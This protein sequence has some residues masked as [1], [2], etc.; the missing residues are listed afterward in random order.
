MDNLDDVIYRDIGLRIREIRVRKKLSQAEL[1]EK[2]Q[3]SLPH[4]SVIEHGK[5]RMSLTSFYR[6]VEALEVSAD[7]ILRTHNKVVNAMD[8]KSLADILSDCTPAESESILKV[9]REVKESMKT[10]KRHS[11]DY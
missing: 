11:E 7:E 10:A 1:A 9:A 6:I 5:T 3:L 8:Q 4:I 2:A